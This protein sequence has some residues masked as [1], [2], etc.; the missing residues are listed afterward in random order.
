MAVSKRIWYISEFFL[1]GVLAA[2]VDS[3][4]TNIATG[5]V[6]LGRNP[7][8]NKNQFNGYLQ[9]FRLYVGTAKYT[10]NF[11]PAATSPDILPDSPSGVSGVLNSP[12]LLM[13]VV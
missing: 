12:S 7:G 1:D 8:N 11:I 5:T 6:D 13:M 4:N 10:Q 2:T 9:D 3:A